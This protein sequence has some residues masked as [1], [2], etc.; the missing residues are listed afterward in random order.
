M[1][2]AH[3]VEIEIEGFHAG[4]MGSPFLVY[5]HLSTDE[6]GPSYS[7]DYHYGV[8]FHERN[9]TIIQSIRKTDKNGC[10]LQRGGRI[11]APGI[12]MDGPPYAGIA[13]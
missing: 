2:C 6:T 7:R 5:I 3:S 8:L 13:D 1:I 10:V 11:D 9:S 12:Y 4:L